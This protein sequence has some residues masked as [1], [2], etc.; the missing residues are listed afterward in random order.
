MPS[1]SPAP[2]AP[3]T[4]VLFCDIDGVLH[5]ASLI[6][7]ADLAGLAAQGADKLLALGLFGL[8]QHL[9]QVL[10]GA[11]A[12]DVMIAIHSSW[13]ATV[14]APPIMRR[15]LGPLGGRFHGFTSAKVPRE[16]SI[17]DLCSRIGVDDHL[18]L[19]DAGH[20]FRERSRLVVTDPLT[21]VDDPEVL[22]RVRE[23]AAG[24]HR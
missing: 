14:W 7:G 19:D 8:S 15:L 10:A 2:F 9:E 4:R 11:G 18:I 16:A 17:I 21:G 5:S 13:R 3:R 23:W 24:D 1:N 20:E 22:A 6:E 12:D